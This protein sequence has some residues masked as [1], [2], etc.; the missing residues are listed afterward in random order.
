MLGSKIGFLATP[1][2]AAAAYVTLDT[3]TG[4]LMLGGQRFMFSGSNVNGLGATNYASMYGATVDAE[5]YHLASHSEIDDQLDQAEAMNATVIRAYGAVMSVGRLSAV[6]PSLGTFSTT[7]LEPIDYALQQL[8][9]RGMKVYFP[10]VDAYDFQPRGAPWYCTANGVTPDSNASQFYNLANTAIVNSFKA[11]ISFV[12]DHTNVYTGIQYKNDPT[13]FCWETGNE[14]HAGT[15]TA[16]NKAWTDNISQYIKVTKGAHQ[17]VMDGCAYNPD[18]GDG[19]H[20]DIDLPYIDIMTHHPYYSGALFVLGN[21]AERAHAHNKAF[22]AGEWGWTGLNPNGAAVDWTLDQFIALVEGSTFVDG[23]NFWQ[24][25]PSLVGVGG[26]SQYGLHFPGDN[27]DMTTRG[28]K[29]AAHALAMQTAGVVPAPVTFLTDNFTGTNGTALGSHTPDSGGTWSFQTGSSGVETIQNNRLYTTSS[30]T[31]YGVYNATPQNANYDVTLTINFVSHV[32]GSEVWALGRM[33]SGAGTNYELNLHCTS[34]TA[35][36]LKLTRWLNGSGA[37]L[38][39]N[40]PIPVAPA[41]GSSHTL[42]LRMRGNQLSALWDDAMQFRI[43]DV[44]IIAK[45][46]AGLGASAV[47]STTG[48]HID[49]IVATSPPPAED[50]TA[51]TTFLTDTFTGTNGTALESHT[52]ETGATWAKHT[53]W[54]GA[55][56]IQANRIWNGGGAEAHY[57]ASGVPTSPDYE[58]TTTIFD[59]TNVTFSL[60]GPMGRMLVGAN[61]AYGAFAI[62]DG[63]VTGVYLKRWV[64]GAGADISSVVITTP[65][66]ASSHTLTLRMDGNNLWALWDGV[67]VLGPVVDKNIVGVGRPGVI[68]NGVATSTTAWHI[69]GVSAI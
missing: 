29:L 4:N 66:A 12:L 65:A 60:A 20:L 36:V 1:A 63:S 30:F 42:T 39:T 17:L 16:T 19:G 46:A 31:N 54:T 50:Q 62:W 59:I 28:N 37:A 3:A 21:S 26:P 34:S 9:L 18:G 2:A 35:Y 6:Q 45:G 64:A 32:A 41:V 48:M 56:T 44:D 47:T 58:V 61:T 22:V 38:V 49:S 7:A 11:H 13:I 5:G 10:L 14:L 57:Y 33:V 55:F 27:S 43:N 69:D 52:G 15:W 67:V 40:V 8:A 23:D 68:S 53:G 51:P 25:I 24:L